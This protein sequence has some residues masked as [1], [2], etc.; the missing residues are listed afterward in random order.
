MLRKRSLATPTRCSPML[1]QPCYFR[2]CYSQS[3]IERWIWL[4]KVGLAPWALMSAHPRALMGA[5][6]RSRPLMTALMSAHERT[7][8]C[9]LIAGI[10]IISQLIEARPTLK[11]TPENIVLLLEI[12]YYLQT[13]SYSA[14]PNKRG[15]VIISVPPGQFPKI[16]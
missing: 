14:V 15:G 3:H 9:D 5:H 16:V 2:Q 12:E 8:L 1:L 10:S 7:V 4:C 11:L 6:E 13:H